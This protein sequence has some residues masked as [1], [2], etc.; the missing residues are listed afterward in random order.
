VVVFVRGIG[1][2]KS[3]RWTGG[4]GAVG[5]EW[6]MAGADGRRG[7]GTSPFLI[8]LGDSARFHSFRV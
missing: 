1:G 8:E 7:G 4:P 2:G 5:A 6:I 3:S